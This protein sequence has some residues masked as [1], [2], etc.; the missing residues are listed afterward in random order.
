MEKVLFALGSVAVFEG[1]FIAVAPN[2]IPKVLE[3]LSKFSNSEL[4]RIGLIIMAIGVAIL[5]VSGI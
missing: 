4:S 2:R 5:M 3:M 1:F